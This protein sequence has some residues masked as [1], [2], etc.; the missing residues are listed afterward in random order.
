MPHIGEFGTQPIDLRPRR[1]FNEPNVEH[2]RLR[3]RLQRQ[4]RQQRQQITNRGD[5]DRRRLF[6]EF[7]NQPIE[8]ALLHAVEFLNAAA[9]ANDVVA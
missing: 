1:A 8:N 6:R 9:L 4:R 2:R 5:V 7:D 3:H